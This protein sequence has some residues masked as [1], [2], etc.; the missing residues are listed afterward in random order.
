MKKIII[1]LLCFSL[2]IV[3]SS[4]KSETTEKSNDTKE[5]VKK[6]KKQEQD[7]KRAYQ[8]PMECEGDKTY[9]KEGKC[10]VCKMKLKEKKEALR[11]N[12]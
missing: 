3:S 7:Q 10:P 12:E 8:C 2:G 9:E 4:C 1:V 6:E 11:A 5:L